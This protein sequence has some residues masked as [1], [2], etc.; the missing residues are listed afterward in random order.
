MND[1]RESTAEDGCLYP[2]LLGAEWRALAPA[3]R[4]AHFGGRSRRLAGSLTVELGPGRWARLFRWVFRLPRRAGPAAT[5]LE[6]AGDGDAETWSR[7]IGDWC[8]V[9]R[10]EAAGEALCEIVRPLAFVFRLEREGEALRYRQVG[11]RLRLPGA[12]LPL[13][14]PLRVTVDALEE[15]AADGAG[16]RLTVRFRFAGRLLFAYHGELE[17]RP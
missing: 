5:T 14:R 2:R 1:E 6:I 4:R 12:S 8:L 13:P 3:V 17:V 10:Q 11:L 9:S 16:T 7:R 15:P